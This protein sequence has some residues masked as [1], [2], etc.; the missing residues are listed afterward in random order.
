MPVRKLMM[1][2]NDQNEAP[3]V[4]FERSLEVRVMT[5]DGTWSGEGFLIDIS[6]TE[7]QIA[8][9]GHAA[10]LTEFFLMLTSCGNPVFR[11]CRREWVDG[12]TVGVSFKKTSIGMKSLEE[13]RREAELVQ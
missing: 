8:V 2:T 4:K 3:R 7:A 6:D 1:R 9:T 12:A 11:R 5:I 13:V 10:A